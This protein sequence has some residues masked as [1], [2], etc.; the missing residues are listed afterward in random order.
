M[1]KDKENTASGGDYLTELVEGPKEFIR[2][3]IHLINRCTK[4]DRKGIRFP[5]ILKEHALLIKS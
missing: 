2:E 4:P 1:Y 5:S 3:S